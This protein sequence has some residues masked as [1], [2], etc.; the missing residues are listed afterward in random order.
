MMSNHN[1][2]LKK[3]GYA[4]IERQGVAL[5][6]RDFEETKQRGSLDHLNIRGV[7]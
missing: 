5:G 6:T 3:K 4:L 2:F 1:F 7:N